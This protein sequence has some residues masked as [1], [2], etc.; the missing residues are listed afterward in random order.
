[1]DDGTIVAPDTTAAATDGA[2]QEGHGEPTHEIV[3]FS[4]LD[5]LLTQHSNAT[6]TTH[7]VLQDLMM[8]EIAAS[9]MIYRMTADDHLDRYPCSDGNKLYYSTVD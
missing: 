5:L 6:H 4:E 8:E 7:E 9:L 1:M 3:T 2:A